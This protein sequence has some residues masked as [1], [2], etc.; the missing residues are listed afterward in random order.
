M[1]ASLK[2]AKLNARCWELEAKEVV[3]RAARAEA[4]RDAARH[5]EAMARMETDVAGSVWAQMESK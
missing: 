5:E 3:D 4:E 1:N 2:D